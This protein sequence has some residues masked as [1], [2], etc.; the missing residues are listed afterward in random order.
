MKASAAMSDDFLALAFD[1][2]VGALKDV[3]QSRR[4]CPP[5]EPS[6]P[7]VN[8]T[9]RNKNTSNCIATALVMGA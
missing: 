6:A 5:R 7:E 1:E 4:V 2:A 3:L 8:I 9:T